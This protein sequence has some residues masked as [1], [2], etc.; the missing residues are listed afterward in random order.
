LFTYVSNTLTVRDKKMARS[1]AI[2][3]A[4]GGSKRIPGKNIRMFHDKPIIAYSIE[5]A[6]GA[7]CFDEVMVS[8]DSAQIAEV[9]QKYGASVP[10]LRSEKNAG[11]FATTAEVII[12]VLEMYRERGEEFDFSCCIYPTAPLLTPEK[13]RRAHKLL[14][15]SDAK[16]VVPVVKF[17][18]PILR[19]F[20][21]ERGLL[22][23]NWPQYVN[24]RSQDLQHAYHDAGQFYLFR[25]ADFIKDRKLFTNNTIGLEVTELEVQD[26]DSETDWAL[27]ELKYSLLT[28]PGA[29]SSY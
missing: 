5:Y 28:K 12:E 7:G 3:T 2:I 16:S 22:E 24:T 18:A 21:L 27:A 23:M 15:E 19:S 4:R 11:D 8:T 29:R 17:P 25:T 1:L 6:I 13:L 9:A 10:F 26:I 20:K 14:I